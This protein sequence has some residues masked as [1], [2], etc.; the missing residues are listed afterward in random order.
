MWLFLSELK[1][2]GL[3]AALA[4]VIF[5][6]ILVYQR[7]IKIED[8]TAE[9]GRQKF[10]ARQAILKERLKRSEVKCEEEQNKYLIQREKYMEYYNINLDLDDPDLIPV[11]GREDPR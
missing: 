7:G 8:L 10:E 5:M 6:M 9:L 1:K 4:A 2:Y 3:I 11:N